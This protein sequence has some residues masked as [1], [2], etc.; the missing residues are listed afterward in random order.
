MRL[1]LLMLDHHD[2]PSML[3]ACSGR[4]SFTLRLFVCFIWGSQ[5]AP[6]RISVLSLPLWSIH[7]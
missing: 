5:M 4:D 2:F 1:W 3:H 7:D 6:I